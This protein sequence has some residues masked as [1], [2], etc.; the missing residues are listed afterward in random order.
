MRVYRGNS[1]MRLKGGEKVTKKAERAV[2]FSLI[3]DSFAGL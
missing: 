1:K 2:S 3:F